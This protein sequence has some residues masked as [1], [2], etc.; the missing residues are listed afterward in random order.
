MAST[1]HGGG[2]FKC[3][4]IAVLRVLLFTF[5]NMQTG[6][7]W[8]SYEKI[9]AAAGYYI[10]TVRKALRALEVVGMIPAT[11]R[12]IRATFMSHAQRLR[13]DV[14]V[15]TNNSYVFN[16]PLPDRPT[17]DGL[18]SP[19][20]QPQPQTEADTRFRRETNHA[21]KIRETAPTTPPTSR[22]RKHVGSKPSSAPTKTA[23]PQHCI[24][25]EF[26]VA[27]MRPT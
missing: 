11:R 20:F 6:E 14:I 16:I 24:R 17:E 1:Q 22:R 18:S 25:K 3:T 2:T 19:L 5:L 9:A 23:E 15:Q 26:A 10:E 13:Y 21:V 27:V 8:P 12:I 7:C 4:R